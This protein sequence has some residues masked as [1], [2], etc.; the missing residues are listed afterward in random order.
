MNKLAMHIKSS[1]FWLLKL[2]NNKLIFTEN[3][4]KKGNM[5]Q[6]STLYCAVHKCCNKISYQQVQLL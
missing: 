4:L 6:Q 1:M 3:C 5:V 2:E